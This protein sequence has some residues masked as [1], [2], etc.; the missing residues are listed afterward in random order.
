MADCPEMEM[1]VST[2]KQSVKQILIKK[3][4]KKYQ[5]EVAAGN[6]TY[7]QWIRQQEEKDGVDTSFSVT[8]E[9]NL[10]NDLIKTLFEGAETQNEGKNAELVE[11][12]RILSMTQTG[13][14]SLTKE[15][16]LLCSKGFLERQMNENSKVFLQSLHDLK[17]NVI[18]I[19]MEE[20]EIASRAFFLCSRK[21]REQ[22]GIVLVYGDEDEKG[23]KI[24]Q[25]PWFKPDWSP[26]SFLSAY[27]LGG[28]L[29]LRT[30]SLSGIAAGLKAKELKVPKIGYL[31]KS[32]DNLTL[33]N[34]F[35]L[36][37][38]SVYSEVK[39]DA[40][41]C[42]DVK[43]D[44]HTLVANGNV[45][46][47]SDFYSR[48]IA[49][50]REDAFF[51]GFGSDKLADCEGFICAPRYD[52]AQYYLNTINE[53]LDYDNVEY[54]ENG[55]EIDKSNALPEIPAYNGDYKGGATYLSRLG[56]TAAP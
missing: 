55:K 27:Y 2:L 30:E 50:N 17:A 28:V 47:A 20:G 42:K 11:E 5:K 41:V 51:C 29:A 23:E 24:R 52:F 48:E 33:L 56:T 32:A 21:L 39:I 3:Q 16:F 44:C 49:D 38:E 22:E 12:C 7:D 1:K 19:N 25:N 9:K 10:T 18:F 45:V 31:L 8:E 40:R 54:D 4:H 36:G 46:I 14:H 43:S 34:A 13:G 53:V 6:L 35:A 26:D 15:L 37:A